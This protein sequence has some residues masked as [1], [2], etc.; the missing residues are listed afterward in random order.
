V[1]R[2]MILLGLALVLL[3][4][5]ILFGSL[6][7]MTNMV[8]PKG[9]A[10]EFAA[11]KGWDNSILYREE[12][13][14]RNGG[15]VY[16]AGEFL[17]TVFANDSLRQKIGG[18]QW[19][20]NDFD[21]YALFYV[22]EPSQELRKQL[23]EDPACKHMEVVLSKCD[24]SLLEL[25]EAEKKFVAYLSTAPE[26]IQNSVQFYMV[27]PHQNRVAVYVKDWSITDQLRLAQAL[28]AD[29]PKFYLVEGDLLE[30]TKNITIGDVKAW[31]IREQELR[32]QMEANGQIVRVDPQLHDALLRLQT[33]QQELYKNVRLIYPEDDWRMTILGA[34]RTP[35][36][37]Q[38]GYTQ[39]ISKIC[40]TVAGDY[41]YEVWE[42][43][44]E[45]LI[46]AVFG[47]VENEFSVFISYG[48]NLDDYCIP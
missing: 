40:Q 35:A 45:Y 23:Q 5:A 47:L 37:S 34:V 17:K 8:L 32:E 6:V 38:Y 1:K 18:M 31:R 42:P 39:I 15:D 14:S 46:R 26:S 10:E 13:K 12:E 19:V 7:Y 41:L 25:A 48:W 29:C 24:Y 2:K 27:M 43:K 22:T 36:L 30:T 28:G 44:Y 4:G 3:T 9:S 16:Q 33:H 11:V 21:H 20:E